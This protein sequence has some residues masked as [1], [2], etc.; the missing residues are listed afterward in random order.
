MSGQ[1]IDVAA[2]CSNGVSAG[3]VINVSATRLI[4]VAT[5][6]LWRRSR[7]SSMRGLNSNLLQ[8][9][10]NS[11]PVLSLEMPFDSKLFY[12]QNFICD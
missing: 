2:A 10:A 7:I 4:N 9:A 6:N 8:L 12:S 5:P 11:T 1:Q 3:Q